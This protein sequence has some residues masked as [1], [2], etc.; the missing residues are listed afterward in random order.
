MIR[1]LIQGT[2][3]IPPATK[4]GTLELK[5]TQVTASGVVTLSAISIPTSHHT[6][7]AGG[8]SSLWQ[9]ECAF[10]TAKRG[11]NDVAKSVNFDGR[12][13]S[14]RSLKFADF[15]MPM[16]PLFHCEQSAQQLTDFFATTTNSR[17][18]HLTFRSTHVEKQPAPLQICTSW[19]AEH[20]WRQ[21][22]KT[23]KTTKHQALNPFFVAS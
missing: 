14:L 23:T 12:N 2:S 13:R 1:I 16:K 21:A 4:P 8:Q 22:R 20:L 7:L 19:P 17:I 11:S 5:G 15:A 10:F 18:T 3:K 6:R 9:L